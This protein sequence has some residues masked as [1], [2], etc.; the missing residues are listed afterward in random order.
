[1]SIY[2]I[3]A[4]YNFISFLIF[5]F[6]CFEW[7]FLNLPLPFLHLGEKS[8]NQTPNHVSIYISFFFFSCSLSCATAPTVWSQASQGQDKG[9]INS[10][11]DG[12]KYKLTFLQ[13]KYVL[14]LQ[15][16]FFIV[17]APTCGYHLQE[18]NISQNLVLVWSSL[19]FLTFSCV[20]PHNCPLIKS[21]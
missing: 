4:S 20:D 8:L 6:L 15:E 11:T 21:H 9:F 17:A 18:I 3:T 14:H 13:Y 1:M 7:N 5:A 16:L 12:T 10:L 2:L 19:R